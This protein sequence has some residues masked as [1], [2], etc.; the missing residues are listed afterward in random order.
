[1][2]P[3]RQKTLLVVLL[4]SLLIFGTLGYQFIEGW[5]VLES[6]YMTIITITTTGF[7]EVNPLS[8]EGRIFTMVLLL[9]GMGTVA[10]SVSFFMSELFSARLGLNRRWRMKKKIAELSGHT[11]LCGYGRMGKIIA[12][13]LSDKDVDFVVIDNQPKNHQE[14]ADYK[15]LVV[16]GDATQDEVLQK[17]GI[18]RAGTVAG[19]L[20]NDADNLYVVLAAKDL[21]PE[22]SIISRASDKDAR[23]KMLR[24]G[25]DKVIMPL[26]MSAK[27]VAHTI[28]NPAAEDYLEISGV[29]LKYDE[30]VQM[31]DLLVDEHP[32]LIGKTLINCGFKREGMIIV[33][34]KTDESFVF[35]PRSDYEFQAGDVL[36]TLSTP[37]HFQNIMN[38]I[39]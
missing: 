10:Y 15:Y 22:V 34:I 9:V 31:S 37:D 3:N 5:G 24:A 32:S 30:R 7:Q 12:K 38:K 39:K 29:T 35:A 1:M 6:F 33:G 18:E 14:L 17:A 21:N 25:S 16:D 11:V 27:K 19:M 20:G 8:P 36:I 23:S 2:N 13:E 26:A 28:L 4:I